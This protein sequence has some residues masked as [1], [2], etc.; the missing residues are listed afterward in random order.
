M[1][2]LTPSQRLF[3]NLKQA[4]PIDSMSYMP[5]E[6]AYSALKERT[7]QDFGYDFSKWELWLLENANDFRL[8]SYGIKYGKQIP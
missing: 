8:G 1:S 7:G 3:E 4:I 5:R 2:L 6:E